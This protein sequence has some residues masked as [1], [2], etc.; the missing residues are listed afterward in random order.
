MLIFPVYTQKIV[1]DVY[2]DSSSVYMKSFLPFFRFFLGGI[3][4]FACVHVY[5]GH[6]IIKCIVIHCVYALYF[7]IVFET[8]IELCG[9]LLN[10]LV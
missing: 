8:L 7:L 9:R 1:N 6:T 3:A 10:S 4:S 5:T 2:F